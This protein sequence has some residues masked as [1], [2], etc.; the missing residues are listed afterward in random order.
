MCKETSLDYARIRTRA[1]FIL[2][3]YFQS[4]PSNVMETIWQ[5]IMMDIVPHCIQSMGKDAE[6]Q[7]THVGRLLNFWK[8]LFPESLINEWVHLLEEQQRTLGIPIGATAAATAPTT[9]SLPA[10]SGKRQFDEAFS[11]TSSAASV[12]APSTVSENGPI[13]P[14][15]IYTHTN[16]DFIMLV[17]RSA[18]EPTHHANAH[19]VTTT[20][21]NQLT[22][23]L[24]QYYLERCREPSEQ[25]YWRLLLLSSVW[26]I[27][28]HGASYQL[29]EDKI[30]IAFACV[31]LAGKVMSMLS[32]CNLLL[33]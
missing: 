16:D 5:P 14:V 13:E 4:L 8:S 19:T 10:A 32:P 30:A 25:V 18:I 21:M 24:C 11:A 17:L 3:K 23:R 9:N 28:K 33:F 20:Q 6:A 26:L 29:G 27:H 7:L 31:Y 2:H 12:P 22:I 15:S 1:F